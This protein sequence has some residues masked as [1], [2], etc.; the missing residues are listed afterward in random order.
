[1]RRLTLEPA[2]GDPAIEAIAARLGDPATPDDHVARLL[3]DAAALAG[4]R[5]DPV[6]L[7]FEAEP[8]S[9]DLAAA[10]RA[11]GL[12]PVRTLLQMRRALPVPPDRRGPDRP[13]GPPRL[14]PFRPGVDDAAWLEVNNRAFA[15]H[16]EQG[17]WTEA[18]LAARRAEPWFRADG[19]LVHD[20]E[21]GPEDG[22][23]GGIDAF[24]WT[25]VHADHDPPLGEIYVIGVDPDAHGSGLGRALTLAGLDWLADH[26]LRVGM[27]YVESDNDAAVGLY[28]DLGFEVH[29]ARRWWRTP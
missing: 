18:D 9:A 12:E 7:V 13:G 29:L 11:A 22:A 17:D 14:R 26:G 21:D 19:F 25:K 5:A 16:P 2:T 20:R 4:A 15:W 24:C 8:T 28:R 10:A 27:L 3:A 23:G 6:G 1:V